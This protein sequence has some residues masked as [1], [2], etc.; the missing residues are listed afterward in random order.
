MGILWEIWEGQ[1]YRQASRNAV[2]EAGKPQA[3]LEPV[4]RVAQ[5][6]RPKPPVSNRGGTILKGKC[7]KSQ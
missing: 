5:A 7:P 3:R 1:Q 6:T 2:G 4:G